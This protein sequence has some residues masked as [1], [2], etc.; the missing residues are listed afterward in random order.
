MEIRLAVLD[1]EVAATKGQA[2]KESTRRNLLTYLNS[3]EQFCKEYLLTCF[4]ADNRQLC[5]F[6]QHL[7]KTSKSADSVGNYQSGVRTCQA[8]LG[9]ELPDPQEEQMQLFTQGL[10]RVMLHEIKQ[11]E[12]ITPQ[13]L[14]KMSTVVNY[15]NHID[16]VAW[17]ATL[18]GFTMFLRKSNLAPEAMEKFNPEQQFTRADIHITNPLAPCMVDIRWTK[19]IQFKQ[20][21]LRLP[22]LP[23]HNKRICPVMWVHY[24]INTIQAE[25][26]DP[27]FTIFYKGQKTALSA[28]QLINR[29]R[30]WL[31]LLKEPEDKYSLHSLRRGG[32]HSHSR[33]I[34]NMK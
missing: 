17:V 13:L 19:T 26:S 6:G 12:P 10:K 33:A 20:R 29:I 7:A 18:M 28:N 3:Y 15:T 31:K 5:R 4:P 9:M 21:I 25:P 23:V 1:L 30:K 34:W 8:L 11:A 27:A 24:M 14:V 22:V 16:M 32:R 2:V